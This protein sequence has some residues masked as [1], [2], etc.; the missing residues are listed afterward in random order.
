MA[1]APRRIEMFKLLKKSFSLFWKLLAALSTI[2]SLVISFLPWDEYD[3][4]VISLIG[5]YFILVVMALFLVCFG[6]YCIYP[7]IIGHVD[8]K[9]NGSEIKITSG[10]LFSYGS[11]FL[12]IVSFNSYFDTHVGDGIIDPSSLN[13]IYISRFYKT[14]KDL[15]QLKN[16]IDNDPHLKSNL[17][18]GCKSL[19]ERKQYKLGT[20]FKDNDYLLLALTNFDEANNARVTLNELAD[21]F[22]RM[23][24][25]IDELKGCYSIV[26]PLLGSGRT[27]RIGKKGSELNVPNQELLELLLGTFKISRIKIKKP[28][29]ITIVL[30]KS[31]LKSNDKNEKVD[32]LKLKEVC[33]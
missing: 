30:Q 29:N 3:N 28:A 15:M 7:R 2:F 21:C 16:R 18:D 11:Q 6:L 8:L 20:I 14:E 24:S 26:I 31:I 32:L 4:K 17:A 10:D 5:I 22:L 1:A 9:I 12:K 23:W 33:Y 13:G 27:T 25:E 19:N